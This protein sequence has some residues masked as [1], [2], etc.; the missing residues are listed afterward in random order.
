[1]QTVEQLPIALPKDKVAAF[2]R[3]H[4]I[5]KLSLFDLVLREDFRRSS[6]QGNILSEVKQLKIVD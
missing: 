3:R 5:H 2:C 6:K 1:M 4:H